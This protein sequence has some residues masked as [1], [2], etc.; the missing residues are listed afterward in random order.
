[1]FH[2]EDALHATPVSAAEAYFMRTRVGHYRAHAIDTH[3]IV[4]YL[5][6]PLPKDGESG[7]WSDADVANLVTAAEPHEVVVFHPGIRTDDLSDPWSTMGRDLLHVSCSDAVIVDARN[8]CGLGVGAEVAQA[9]SLGVRVITVAPEQSYYVRE[10][11]DYLGQHLERWTHPF[12]AC[13]SDE[14]VASVD[15]AGR[16]IASLPGDSKTK[17]PECFDTALQRYIS[18]QLHRDEPMAD[19]VANVP[20]VARRV[21][22]V[23]KRLASTVR[24]RRSAA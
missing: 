1:V 14:I 19:S 6:G 21:N 7:G 24:T 2:Q 16:S 9:K 11:C 4:V 5:A 17:G 10:S 23:R 8:A 20:V 13:L 22:R 3:P 15:A 18:T 12:I